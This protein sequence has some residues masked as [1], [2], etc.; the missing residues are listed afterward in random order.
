M[1]QENRGNGAKQNGS[2][3]TQRREEKYEMHAGAAAFVR[4]EIERHLPLFEFRK[5]YPHTYITTVYFDTEELALYRI[6]REFYDDNVKVRLKEYCYRSPVPARLGSHE[7][8]ASR[9]ITLETCFLEIKQRY[10]AM[11]SKRRLEVPKRLFGRLIAGQDVWDELVSSREGIEFD[12]MLDTYQD[13]RQ[14]LRHYK[15]N[16]KSII[17]YRRSVYQ[18]DEQELRITFDDEI[19]VFPAIPGLYETVPALVRDSLGPPTGCIEKLTLEIKSQD[20]YPQ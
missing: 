18:E 3:F 2:Y 17:N 5:G 20:K 10:R 4:N 15:V 6:A 14:Y 8:S 16:P 1:G 12:G 7:S 13:F 11:V 19:A 9:W